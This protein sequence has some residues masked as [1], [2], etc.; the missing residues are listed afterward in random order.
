MDSKAEWKLAEA[1]ESPDPFGDVV[2]ST[3]TLDL[4]APE[5][6]LARV[7]VDLL[8]REGR[9][10]Q[11]GITCQLKDGG[12][13]C[14]HCPAATLDATE[15]RSVLCRLGKD[16]SALEHEREDRCTAQRAAVSDLAALADELSEIGA[17]P[18]ELLVLLSEVGP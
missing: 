3:C 17:M 14:L 1:M 10:A 7:F 11:N 13:D 6:E 8:W 2:Y 12:Q 18:D 9:L 16:E 5:E 4:T 15:A